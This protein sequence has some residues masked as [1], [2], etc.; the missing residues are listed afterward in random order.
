MGNNGY[1]QV[2]DYYGGPTYRERRAKAIVG[3]R[4]CTD[5]RKWRPL[6]GFSRKAINKNGSA[7]LHSACG[8][9]NPKRLA[10]WRRYTAKEKVK[11]LNAYAQLR[12]N[13]GITAA[14]YQGLFNA[15][16]GRCRICEM[17]S[18]QRLCV[19]HDHGTGAIRGLLCKM[20]NSG[21]GYFRDDEKLLVSALRYLTCRFKVLQAGG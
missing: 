3:Q 6:V 19:D 10:A 1:A 20:C 18:K 8:T 4:W 7:A 14:Q 21:L 5:C 2:K 16:H 15:Q 9:C 17:K 13:Y 12:R 11:R